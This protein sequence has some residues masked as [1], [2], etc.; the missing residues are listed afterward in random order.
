MKFLLSR[1]NNNNNIFMGGGVFKETKNSWP[2]YEF[3]DL[4]HL[5]A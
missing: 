3:K 1:N 2:Y 5:D 4:N